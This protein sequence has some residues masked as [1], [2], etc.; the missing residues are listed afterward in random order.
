MLNAVSD[1]AGDTSMKII[2]AI[3]AGERDAKKLAA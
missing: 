3:C 2:R 1:I